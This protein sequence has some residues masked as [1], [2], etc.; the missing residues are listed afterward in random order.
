MSAPVDRAFEAEGFR[1]TDMEGGTGRKAGFYSGDG[2][3]WIIVPDAPQG[4]KYLKTNGTEWLLTGTTGSAEVDWTQ[5]A[6]G[7]LGV[8]LAWRF[9]TTTTEADP[10][11]RN[12][13]FDNATPASITKFFISDVTENNGDA[14]VLLGLLSPGSKI[15]IQQQDDAAT[16]L[17]A[18]VVTVTDNSGWFTIDVTIDGSGTLP[19]NNKSL[20][21]LLIYAAG[22]SAALS[23]SKA[24]TIEAPTAS[25]DLSVFFTER[26]I[27]ITEMRAV[28]R[29]STPS[30]TWTIRHAA[31]RAAAGIEVVTGGTTTTSQ[32]TGS[33]V[34]SF[35][36]A[37]IPAD[38]FVWLE[39][40]ART[41]VV[42]EMSVTIV[43][44][45]D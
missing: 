13:R 32:T 4:S 30:I 34:T 23:D 44:G 25:E 40:T 17:L 42:A 6:G 37:T 11:S 33:D 21:V 39:T 9:S 43:Y 38:S 29:G 15:Y 16:A 36:D 24:I 22:G 18:T 41:P 35:D 2:D 27:T 7:G 20:G 8:Q 19:G 3:P 1:V 28:V 14:S 12:L 26:A 10:G 5:S 45:I 31:D